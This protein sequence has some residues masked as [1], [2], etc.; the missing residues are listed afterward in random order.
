[1]SCVY[2]LPKSRIRTRS[3][4]ASALTQP[5]LLEAVVRGFPRDHHV[6]D[7]ALLERGG[8][9][10]HEARLLAQLGEIRR[11][12]VAHPRAQAAHELVDAAR[13]AAAIRHAAL[14][15]LGHELGG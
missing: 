11:A 1:M 15:A 8:R 13:E 5:L 3:R 4:W 6:V 9:D 10:A 7:V 14:D 12:A 2:W